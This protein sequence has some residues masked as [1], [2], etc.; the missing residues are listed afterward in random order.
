MLKTSFLDDTHW[1]RTFRWLLSLE[2]VAT[3]TCSW[4]FFVTGM[5][6]YFASRNRN[7]PILERDVEENW[8]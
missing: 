5:K 7:M 8:R 1:Q 2:T 6:K 4:I 3:K